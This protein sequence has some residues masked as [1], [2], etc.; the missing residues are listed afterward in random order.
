MRLSVFINDKEI[1]FITVYIIYIS[2][3]LYNLTYEML[4]VIDIYF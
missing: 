3:F 4:F 1:Q 2:M